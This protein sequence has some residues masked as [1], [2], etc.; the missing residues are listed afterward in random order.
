MTGFYSCRKTDNQ[1]EDFLYGFGGRCLKI[2]EVCVDFQEVLT[3]NSST[4]VARGLANIV[5]ITVS[6][7]RFNS[8]NS[9]KTS[10]YFF[11]PPYVGRVSKIFKF[12]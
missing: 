7:R 12:F 5:G 8:S 3:T 11:K 4:N 2:K 6:T 1:F 10:T 9:G